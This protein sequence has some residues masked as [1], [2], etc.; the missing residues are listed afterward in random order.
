MP[1]TCSF[2]LFLLWQNT[3]NTKF[4]IVFCVQH[5]ISFAWNFHL[6][7]APWPKFLCENL[8]TLLDSPNFL[9]AVVPPCRQL[10][11]LSPLS[12]YGFPK[13]REGLI[14]LKYP[15]STPG[16]GAQ[17]LYPLFH[18][19]LYLCHFYLCLVLPISPYLHSV[20]DHC[21]KSCLHTVLSPL[22]CPQM[23]WKNCPRSLLL[24]SEEVGTTSLGDSCTATC[25][26][27]RSS[28]KRS[29]RSNKWSKCQIQLQCFS[30]YF[31][32]PIWS[33]FKN[34]SNICTWCNSSLF[35]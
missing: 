17:L 16:T 8:K 15:A 6:L 10:P 21:V 22:L 5:A 1:F 31:K 19:S 33:I 27:L 4:T 18:P 24:Q 30:S 12:A 11:C 3:H 25:F 20:L 35:Y 13:D 23:S 34:E 29:T 9:H 7:I 14:L 26:M 28:Q 32:W 2:S